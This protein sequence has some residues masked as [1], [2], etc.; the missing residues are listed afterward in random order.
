MGGGHINQ[1]LPRRSESNAPVDPGAPPPGERGI[2]DRESDQQGRAVCI[3][4]APPGIGRL[5][6]PRTAAVDPNPGK[7]HAFADPAFRAPARDPAHGI[8]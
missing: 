5:L 3:L 6:G 7:Q 1:P 8:G 4:I 2:A